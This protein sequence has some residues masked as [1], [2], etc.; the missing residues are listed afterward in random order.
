MS[1]KN[2]PIRKKLLLFVHPMEFFLRLL[3]SAKH[4][5]YFTPLHFV[6][7]SQQSHEIIIFKNKV[8]ASHTRLII[9]YTLQ[10]A[11]KLSSLLKPIKEVNDIT[12]LICQSFLPSLSLPLLLPFISFNFNMLKFKM[13]VLLLTIAI[14]LLLCLTDTPHMRRIHNVIGR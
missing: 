10:E 12:N 6:G 1:K 5:H 7:C 9:H 8:A 3:Q 2:S 13:P 14:F 4:S 11:L